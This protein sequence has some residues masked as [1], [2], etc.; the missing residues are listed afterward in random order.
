MADRGFAIKDMLKELGA[1]LNLPP[2][3][4]Q[5]S[6]E[7]VSKGHSIASLRIHVERAIGR[8]K[9]YKIVSGTLCLKLARIAN[10]LL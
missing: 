9:T 6:A 8:V 4:K 7:E 10:Q 3:L 2:F 5:F 1:E